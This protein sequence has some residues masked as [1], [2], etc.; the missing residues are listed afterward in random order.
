[1]V[2]SGTA[3]KELA[4]V[5]AEGMRYIIPFEMASQ[6]VAIDVHPARRASRDF[7]HGY[8]PTFSYAVFHERQPPATPLI[9][10]VIR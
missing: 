8:L 2:L 5:G 1:M 10:K 3:P 6:S 9:A 7:R 4:Q